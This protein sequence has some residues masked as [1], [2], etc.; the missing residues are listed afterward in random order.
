[1]YAIR[2]YYVNYIL[3]NDNCVTIEFNATSD[4]TTWV[5]MSNHCYFNLSGDFSESALN[6]SLRIN[7][8]KF[9]LNNSESI[10]QQ[11]A[12]VKGTVFDFTTE[13]IINDK[14]D[15]DIQLS[16]ARGYNHTFLLN[17][18][19]PAVELIDKES[20]RRLTITT[21]YPSLVFYSS[22]V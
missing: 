10:C 20:G 2:S 11:I 14:I 1:M 21:D 6:H 5:N 4:K 22:V 12:D 8:D 3:D 19:D 18:S 15:D 17:N 7:A 13:S 9:F 16:Y